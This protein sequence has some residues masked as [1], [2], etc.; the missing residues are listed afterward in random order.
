MRSH[1]PPPFIVL[2]CAITIGVFGDILF[3]ADGLGINLPLWLILIVA[4][5]FACSLYAGQ[6]LKK[7][8]VAWLM[9]TLLCA[10]IPAIRA[11]EFLTFLSICAALLAVGFAGLAEAEFRLRETHTARLLHGLIVNGAISLFGF[12]HWIPVSRIVPSPDAYKP[13]DG[14][15]AVFRGAVLSTPAAVLFLAL[16]A[17]ADAQY[18]GYLLNIFD[19]DVEWIMSHVYVAVF[20]AWIALAML[21]FFFYGDKFLP[22]GESIAPDLKQM[23]I[24]LIVVTVVVTIIFASYVFVQLGYLFGGVQHILDTPDLTLAEYAR[25]GFFESAAACAMVLLLLQTCGEYIERRSRHHYKA[26]SGVSAMLILLSLIVVASGFQ[27]IMIYTEHFGLTQDRFYVYVGLTWIACC[28]TWMLVTFILPLR[29]RFIA[30]AIGLAYAALFTTAVLNPD[31]Y[32][33]S[34]NIRHFERTGEFDGDYVHQLS[35]DAVP[36]L[37]ESRGIL[38]E[39]IWR[40]IDVMRYNRNESYSR[41]GYWA[42]NLGHERSI[43]TLTK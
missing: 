31:R 16:F 19:V 3:R 30:G 28:L 9:I 4:A 39:D 35:A 33:A 37:V 40:Y 42:W 13:N 21:V 17:S 38:G 25:R 27:R 34:T 1:T 14:M 41:S 23:V 22:T 36:V 7:S 6:T 11:A 2:L 26:F 32:V 8:S 18:E 5:M 20:F 12:L 43:R 24:E 29:R 10:L 15:L